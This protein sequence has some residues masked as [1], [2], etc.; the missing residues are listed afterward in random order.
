MHSAPAAIKDR[1]WNCLQKHGSHFDSLDLIPPDNCSG[2]E[3]ENLRIADEKLESFIKISPNLTRLE[4]DAGQLTMRSLNQLAQQVPRLNSLNFA[5]R[6]DI[7]DDQYGFLTELKYLK[8]LKIENACQLTQNGFGSICS[9]A[10][11]SIYS[12]HLGASSFDKEWLV[13]FCANQHCPSEIG[14]YSQRLYPLD[15]IILFKHFRTKIDKISF[16]YSPHL[17]DEIHQLIRWLDANIGS[18][19]KWYRS[20]KNGT[21]EVYFEKDS[22]SDSD[23]D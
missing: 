10:N 15:F 20:I 16:K 2:A 23:S 13:Q 6:F 17:D 22:D 8:K 5:G 4:I 1:L 18:N 9:V 11:A 12:L 19:G 21:C 3:R 7:P 14:F